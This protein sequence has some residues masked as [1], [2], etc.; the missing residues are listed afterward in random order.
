MTKLLLSLLLPLA[1]FAQSEASR[2]NTFVQPATSGMIVQPANAASLSVQEATSFEIDLAAFTNTGSN[3]GVCS[4]GEYVNDGALQAALAFAAQTTAATGP[5]YGNGG[6]VVRVPQGCGSLDP[7]GTYPIDIPNG[8]RLVG[9]DFHSS[10]FSAPWTIPANTILFRIGP[11]GSAIDAAGIEEMGIAFG[12]NSGTP[13]TFSANVSASASPQ[14]VAVVNALLIAPAGQTGYAYACGSAAPVGSPLITTGSCE[15]V[16]VTIMDPG[17]VSGVFTVA[18]SSGAHLT[19]EAPP[20]TTCI[21]ALGAQ[22]QSR[23]FHVGCYNHGG[24]AF[25]WGDPANP[26]SIQ[27]SGA[28]ELV[29]G[30]AGYPGSNGFHCYQC[31][32]RFQVDGFTLTS[33]YADQYGNGGAGVF[34][35]GGNNLSAKHGHCEDPY[36]PASASAADPSGADCVKIGGGGVEVEDVTGQSFTGGGGVQNVVHLLNGSG[37]VD[38]RNISGNGP[39]ALVL[40]E[41]NNC[42]LSLAPTGPGSGATATATISGGVIAT[43]ALTAGGSG[44]TSG[45]LVEFP[46]NN[47]AALATVAGGVV[48][49]LTLTSGGGGYGSPPAIVIGGGHVC[50][51][52]SGSQYQMYYVKSYG[53]L[54]TDIQAPVSSWGNTRALQNMLGNAVLGA[55]SAESGLTVGYNGG[56]SP[57]YGFSVFSG[58][59]NNTTT[60]GLP[61]E[62]GLWQRLHDPGFGSGG[63]LAMWA[64][65]AASSDQ[66]AGGFC[67]GCSVATGSAFDAGTGAGASLFSMDLGGFFMLAYGGPA[68][69]MSFSGWPAIQFTPALGLVLSNTSITFN[70]FNGT[71]GA[72]CNSSANVLVQCAASFT[73][74]STNAVPLGWTG[75][76]WQ[77][78]TPSTLAVFESN[79]GYSANNSPIAW[80]TTGYVN[81][82]P[83]Q[84]AS[85][86]GGGSLAAGALTY[87]GTDVTPV[88]GVT[89]STCTHW[90][91][92]ICD[93]L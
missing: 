36:Q 73:A 19:A 21:Q 54:L 28:Y 92:G 69:L 3:V 55:V 84:M 12:A 51:T 33:N 56:D 35:D 8:T 13:T 64:N 93:H 17:H 79:G 90:T 60:F 71:A 65:N 4:G 16:R 53:M 76:A 18:H 49:A 74:P 83:A 59:S 22:E 77:Y 24:D 31:I 38:I 29:A 85:Y 67:A 63:A 88:S 72:V 50:V 82:T 57:T 87:N 10:G 34:F 7:S 48:T 2:V 81:W 23:I 41:S 1:V 26:F 15:I 11:T 27:N 43:L 70:A 75:T 5:I 44:Y 58:G 62:G 9:D 52:Y 14:T 45:A 30:G 32:S 68:G 42:D 37:A 20:G 40:D 89:G 78:F 80:G 86:L 39:G 47:G 46:F 66:T 6:G 91:S 61:D 25:E